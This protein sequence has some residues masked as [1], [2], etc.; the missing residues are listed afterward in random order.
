[1]ETVK[2]V[3][4]VPSLL[5]GTTCGREE[6]EVEASTLEGCVEALLARHPQLEVHLFENGREMRPH[7]NLFLGD[8][9]VRWLDDWRRPLA[10]GDTLTILQ[11]VSGGLS[12]DVGSSC[13][14]LYVPGLDLRPPRFSVLHPPRY[15]H[16]PT[17]ASTAPMRSRSS[18]G[19]GWGDPPRR[20]TRNR[21]LRCGGCPPGCEDEI[22]PG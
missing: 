12:P 2:V 15:W 20:V 17:T 11:A 3:I 5:R 6:V 10:A 21:P 19:T 13:R 18:A 9:N 1:M 14:P 8:T 7:V 16:G 4:Y 22:E